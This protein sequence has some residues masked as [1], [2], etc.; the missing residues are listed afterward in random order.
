MVVRCDLQSNK[1]FFPLAAAYI[2]G[3]S[4]HAKIKGTKEEIKVFSEV[5]E[6]SRVVYEMLQGGVTTE[7]MSEALADKSKK[8]QV[9]NNMFGHRWPF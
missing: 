8:A 1:N 9:F 2:L 7:L 6:S 4:P 5:L 3:L